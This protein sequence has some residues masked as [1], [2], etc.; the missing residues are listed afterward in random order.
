MLFATQGL[1][2]DDVSSNYVSQ[3]PV[4]IPA[5]TLNRSILAISDAFDVDIL[6]PNTLLDGKSA[7]AVADARRVQDALEQVL[8]GSGLT[9]VST[10]GAFVIQRG[11]DDASAEPAPIPNAPPD[12]EDSSLVLDTIVVT[13]QKIQRSLQD[14]KESV[15]VITAEIA[16]E[17][18]LLN[19]ADAALQT[20]N[21]TALG[22][23]GANV[24]IRGVTGAVGTAA[25]IGGSGD[26][27][28][29]L[30][31]N[32]P[33]IAESRVYVPENLWDVEQIE[34]LRGP[35]STNVGRSALAGAVVI[36][37]IA[38]SLDG[39]DSAVRLEY[40][41]FNTYA[42]EGMINVPLTD[43]TA[44]R[45]T[46]S[47]S[48]TD[49]FIA[50][51][52][53]GDETGPQ[54]T[55]VRGRLLF[56]PSDD[57]RALASVQL[58]DEESGVSEYIVQ[59]GGDFQ[60]FVA[61]NNEP[62]N[63]AYEGIIGSL[64]LNYRVSDRWELN[65]VTSF[66]DGEYARLTDLDRTALSLGFRDEAVDEQTVTQELRLSYESERLRGTIGGFYLDFDSDADINN[67]TTVDVSLAGAPAVVL[68]FY[69]NPT[70]ITGLTDTQG[71]ITNTA[72]YTQ[73]E[74]DLTER[75]RVSGG[76]RYDR[77]SI[78][79]D[80]GQTGVVDPSTP[81]P[82]PMQAGQVAEMQQPG[83]G[84][85]VQAVVTQVN[86]LLLSLAPSAEEVFE[87]DFSAFLPELGV[88]FAAT[89]NV[90]VSA[91]YKRGYR[92]GGA[93]VLADAT[94]NTFD[95]EYLDNFEVAL[96]SV[97]LDG[98]LVFNANA[99]FGDW[100]DQQLNVPIDGDPL[101]IGTLNV[102][103]SRLWGFELQGDYT[104]SEG[105]TVFAGV[106]YAKTEFREA[107]RIGS[108]FAD[109][110]DCAIDGAAGKDLNGNEFPFSSD[111]TAAIGLRHTF[112]KDWFAQLNATYQSGRFSD[113]EN[114]PMFESDG[115][116]LLNASVGYT[117]ERM[118][119]TAYGRNLTDEFSTRDLVGSLLPGALRVFPIAP[120]QYGVILSARF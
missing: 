47:R 48:D 107:C 97:L 5:G 58:V 81:L 75:L 7:P 38:P 106:G 15:A 36:R 49:G 90:S 76:F 63:F 40:G 37:S 32:V 103:T 14:T 22:N 28:V 35:Q 62:L 95:P 44:F 68:P 52:V 45:L 9:Y 20:P 99:Y 119:V 66:L 84:V 18:T 39:F 67:V 69:A 55:S 60:S 89:P 46:A 10:E 19:V 102:G 93:R 54:S 23:S 118:S 56:E 85:L 83:S 120:R 108:S 24:T 13:G 98:D 77:E 12:V 34:Y 51:T 82:D 11:D 42:A 4:A 33:F 74:F 29:I 110:P 59:N 41:N 53:I 86:G 8:N 96:R 112:A 27:S 88:T 1:A 114:D 113:V 80:F 6:A 72:I 73:W 100:T 70:L 26:V 65:S 91:F 57:F 3:Q 16:R 87:T 79:R 21:I 31:D 94:L 115:Y 71:G 43:T 117:G 61:T 17:R 101:N 30:Y 25:A 92:A 50:N 111:L 116:S 64:E 104:V 2:A 109:L 78:E 105:T